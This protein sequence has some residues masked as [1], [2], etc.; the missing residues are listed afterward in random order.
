MTDRF[1]NLTYGI[2]SIYKSL[3]RIK[4]HKMNS[5][6]LKGT[7]VMCIYFLNLYH[8][9]L[10]ASDLC[11]KCKEDKAGISRILAELYENDFIYYEDNNSEKKKYRAKI[12]LTEKGLKSAKELNQMILESTDKAGTGLTD[13]ERQIFYK[14]LFIIADNLNNLCEQFED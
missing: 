5:I 14:A 10:T 7:H 4:R 6:G 3:Q 2:S 8:N 9:G 11:E 13:E 1:E 12:L